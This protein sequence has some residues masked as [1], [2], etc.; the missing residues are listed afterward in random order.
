MAHFF[1][2]FV[3]FSR[4]VSLFSSLPLILHNQGAIFEKLKEHVALKDELCL[5]SFLDLC[6]AFALDLQ[7]PSRVVWILLA[8][9]KMIK[10]I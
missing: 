3:D 6:S 9:G 10:I 7:V 2:G 4:S 8:K 1:Q 5:E